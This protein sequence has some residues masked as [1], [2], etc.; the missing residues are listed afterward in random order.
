M[1]LE[2]TATML[3]TK[4]VAAIGNNADAFINEG[5]WIVC[6]HGV[7]YYGIVLSNLIHCYHA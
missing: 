4:E 1:I 3:I 2:N 7:H 6:R 5:Y